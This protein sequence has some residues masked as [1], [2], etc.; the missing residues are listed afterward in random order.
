M[1]TLNSNE[2]NFVSGGEGTCGPSDGASV[3]N[4]YGGILDTSTVGDEIIQ[5][6]EG[7]IQATSYMI[8]R[9]ANALP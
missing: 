5:L 1:R 4:E 9:V 8:E 3:G 6:Y 2:L 7:L